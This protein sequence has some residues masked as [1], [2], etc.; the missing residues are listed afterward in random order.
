MDLRD[1]LQATSRIS[2]GPLVIGGVGLVLLLLGARGYYVSGH[3]G[4]SDGL[5]CAVLL[6]P[7]AFL[8][9]VTGYLIQHAKV[10]GVLPVLFAALTAKKYDSFAVAMGVALIGVVAIPAINEWKRSKT[11]MN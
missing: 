1:K 10:V 7:A 3:F 11:G 9:L 8:L 5:T 6:V 2:W 4:F